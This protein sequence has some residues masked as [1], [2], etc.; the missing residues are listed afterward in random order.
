MRKKAIKI[1][2]EVFGLILL[3]LLTALFHMCSEYKKKPGIHE[4][5]YA[6]QNE[7]GVRIVELEYVEDLYNLDGVKKLSYDYVADGKESKGWY[8]M[9]VYINMPDAG[10]I[11][12]DDLILNEERMT[13]CVLKIKDDTAYVYSAPTS[14][15]VQSYTHIFRM[16]F[17]G[18]GALLIIGNDELSETHYLEKTGSLTLLNL[19]IIQ[20]VLVLLT[21]IVLGVLI[22]LELRSTRKS[23]LIKAIVLGVLGIIIFSGVII[24]LN[25][26]EC[27]EYEAKDDRYCFV[28]YNYDGNICEV[29]FG[30]KDNHNEFTE[31]TARYKQGKIVRFNDEVI[32]N[33][34]SKYAL[35]DQYSYKSISRLMVYDY[36]AYM[37]FVVTI[38]IAAGMFFIN[39]KKRQ[40]IIDAPYHGNYVMQDVVYL[41]SGIK[42]MEKYFDVN[43]REDMIVVLPTEFIYNGEDICM[44]EYIVSAIKKEI[45]PSGGIFKGRS[46]KIESTDYEICV[47]SKEAYL[48]KYMDGMLITVYRIR[49]TEA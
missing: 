21:M 3:I 25:T 38:I 23:G 16:A 1:L 7:Y 15:G 26:E 11:Q 41:A 4:G 29:Y 46:I 33:K 18:N 47:N 19:Q 35:E 22:G 27:I 31:I 49:K 2:V 42:G 37:S 20:T 6:Y 40:E 24:K 12:Y 14:I 44:P 10:R 17:S 30:K 36:V 13:T 48:L 9:K 8:L 5:Q 45:F 34:A 43:S 32:F 39:R 28:D